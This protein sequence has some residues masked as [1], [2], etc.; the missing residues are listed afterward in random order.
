MLPTAP[1]CIVACTA[2]PM[3]KPAAPSENGE[4]NRQLHQRTKQETGATSEKRE[5]IT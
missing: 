4:D 5:D 2:V 1:T 3:R